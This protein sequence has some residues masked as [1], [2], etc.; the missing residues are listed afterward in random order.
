M[1]NPT[2]SNPRS[3]RSRPRS[4]VFFAAFIVVGALLVLPL[5]GSASAPVKH[6]TSIVQKINNSTLSSSPNVLRRIFDF[7][8]PMP[9][10]API[11][12]TTYAGVGCA[13]PKSVFNL[14]EP[15]D[16]T[17]CAT[18]TGAQATQEIIWSNANFIA[19]QQTTVG[20]DSNFTFTLGPASV[21][22]TGE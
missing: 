10:A 9:Q 15:G 13:T 11:T 20:T 17:V 6:K 14:Q 3:F 7:L 5:F 8:L 2:P 21:L 12:L 18:V 4:Y 1:I 22:V 19:V 16:L